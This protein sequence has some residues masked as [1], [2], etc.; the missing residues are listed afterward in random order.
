MPYKLLIATKRT[1]IVINYAEQWLRKHTHKHTPK[2][3]PITHTHMHMPHNGAKIV[4]PSLCSTVMIYYLRLIMTH[5]VESGRHQAGRQAAELT[6]SYQ[7]KGI[8]VLT[9]ELH[10][11]RAAAATKSSSS[12][13]QSNCKWRERMRSALFL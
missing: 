8:C 9:F 6:G 4:S 1:Q 5:R 3:T 11:S 13:Y 10:S 12:S 7:N 2:H